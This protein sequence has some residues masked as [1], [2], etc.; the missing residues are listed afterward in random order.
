[1]RGIPLLTHYTPAAVLL[2]RPIAGQ[3]WAHFAA[4]CCQLGPRRLHQCIAQCCRCCR[5]VVAA[6]TRCRCR[7]RCVCFDPLQDSV[8]RTPL[9]YAASWGH[10]DCINAVLS[11]H[12][13]PPKP[14]W[15]V[16]YPND[17][18]TR[19]VD[20]QNMAGFTPLHYAVWVGRKTAIQVRVVVL[21]AVL[22]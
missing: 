11:A 3:R 10:A 6:D 2:F 20:V 16:A 22:N 7:C 21:P 8:G 5:C 15:G 19:L 1:M 12:S 18:E 14:E 4:L 17:D 9:H 13:G